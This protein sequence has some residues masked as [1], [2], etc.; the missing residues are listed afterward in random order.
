MSN[1]G[2][3]ASVVGIVGLSVVGGAVMLWPQDAGASPGETGDIPDLLKTDAVTQLAS[4]VCACTDAGVVDNKEIAACVLRRVYAESDLKWPP[5]AGAT[6]SHARAWEVMTA[7]IAE[8]S[9]KAAAASV[10]VCTYLKSRPQP[11]TPA[12]PTGPTPVTPTV[13]PAAP[14]APTPVTP[15]VPVKWNPQDA[16]G[17]VAG[18]TFCG[19][20]PTKPYNK[21]EWTDSGVEIVD[22]MEVLGFA[23]PPAGDL[24]T[25]LVL[26]AGTIEG[27]QRYLN[28]KGY[29][30]MIGD[31]PLDDDG[32]VGACTLRAMSMAMREE[33]G[34]AGA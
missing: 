16:E 11:V 23:M 18:V 13:T 7:W 15:A 27:L 34:G 2:V 12:A 33:G 19:D 20:N 32:V 28:A 25:R 26:G 5:P 30:G 17:F 14:A 4:L 29:P 24:G 22:A 6:A 1:A 31:V 21:N 10:D 9:T 3:V 8:A